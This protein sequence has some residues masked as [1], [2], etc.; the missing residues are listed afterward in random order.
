MSVLDRV[1]RGE[2]TAFAECV[3]RY[4]GLVWGLARRMTRNAADAEDAVQEIFLNLWKAAARYDSQKGSEAVFIATIARR[5]LIDRLRQRQRRPVEVAMDD[6]EPDG[7]STSG[8]GETCVEAERAAA[9]LATLRPEQQQ[10]IA[11]SVV[12]GLTQSE[13][14]TKTGMPLGTVK[15]LMRRGLLLIRELLGEEVRA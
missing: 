14:A 12:D 1:A 10:V 5:A 6:L 7:W 8:S 11:L 4:G 9:A 3:D 13:I 2:G 15:T